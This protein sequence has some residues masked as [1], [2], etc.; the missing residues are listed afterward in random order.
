[1]H[2]NEPEYIFDWQYKYTIHYKLNG[3]SDNQKFYNAI[4]NVQK[5][6]GYGQPCPQMVCFGVNQWMYFTT[7]SIDVVFKEWGANR[8]GRN[9]PATIYHLKP[10]IEEYLK[11]VDGTITGYE[12][13]ELPLVY[14]DISDKLNLPLEKKIF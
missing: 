8:E 10:V 12:L 6:Y 13:K 7:F 3:I 11:E 5:K 1:M 9:W 2:H 4:K 14:N